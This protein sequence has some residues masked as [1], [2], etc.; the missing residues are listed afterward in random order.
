MPGAGVETRI[1][2]GTTP[3]NRKMQECSCHLRSC[4]E[5]GSV[6][7][8]LQQRLIRRNVGDHEAMVKSGG[9]YIKTKPTLGRGDRVWTI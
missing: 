7:P 6:G 1:T 2:D 9:K 4:L 5:I 3:P 8:Y